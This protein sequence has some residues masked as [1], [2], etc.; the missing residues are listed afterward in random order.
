[1]ST[2]SAMM[3]IYRSLTQIAGGLHVVAGSVVV[4][5]VIGRGAAP[6]R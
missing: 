6:R 2:H 4:A 1:M 5:A 3:H